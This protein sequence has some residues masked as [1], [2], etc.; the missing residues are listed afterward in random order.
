MTRSLAVLRLAHDGGTVV[1]VDVPAV[2]A[3]LGVPVP[4]ALESLLATLP[5]D[6]RAICARWAPK[7]QATFAAGRQALR[8]ALVEAGVVADVAAVGAIGRD[9]RGA[10]VLPAH[11]AHLRRAVSITHKDSVAGALVVVDAA[12]NA[13]VDTVATVAVGCDLELDPVAGRDRHSMAGLA[14][15]VLSPHELQALVDDAQQPLDDVSHRRAVLE[16]FSLKEALY[17]GLDPF[18]RRH[19]GFL[20]VG[21][22][23][24]VDGAALFTVPDA[25]FTATGRVLVVPTMP[26]VVLTTARVQRG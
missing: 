7:R 14:R 8:L 17:K 19:V 12:V 6:E 15:Q 23:V 25:G 1:L 3:G 13:G 10:P 9:D 11:L 5:A 21:V 16:R 24:D 2:A 26:T 4:P 22:R 18:V 20:E